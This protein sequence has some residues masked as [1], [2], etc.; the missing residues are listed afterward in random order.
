MTPRILLGMAGKGA[1][2]LDPCA[3]VTAADARGRPARPRPAA[4][5]A[6]DDRDDET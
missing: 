1:P 4:L 5:E 6:R 2:S 3:D